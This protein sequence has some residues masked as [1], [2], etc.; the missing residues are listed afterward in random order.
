M[1]QTSTN[2]N[3][4]SYFFFT[5]QIFGSEMPKVTFCNLVKIQFD[6]LLSETVQLLR[7]SRCFRT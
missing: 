2:E 3:F 4:D 7:K 5:M 6:A 1:Y